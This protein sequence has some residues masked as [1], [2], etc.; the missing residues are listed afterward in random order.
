MRS[1]ILA[2][3]ARETE[4]GFRLVKLSQ[5]RRIDGCISLAM[6]C[7]EAKNRFMFGV[8]AGFTIIDLEDEPQD[9]DDRFN[10]RTM[11]VIKHDDFG[12]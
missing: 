4:R 6:S 11:S 8:E 1:H 5:N 3:F 10:W 7:L 2:A 9:P 12:W